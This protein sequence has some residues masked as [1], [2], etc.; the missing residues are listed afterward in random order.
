MKLKSPLSELYT[1]DKCSIFQAQRLAQEIAFG[2]VVFQVSR[3]MVKFGILQALN[4]NPRG[5]TLEEIASS[6]KLSV[7]AAKVLLEASLSIGTVIVKEDRFF[8]TKAGWYLINDR[9][10]QVNM[11]FVQ[12]V[13]YLGMFNLEKCLLEGKP[14]GLKIF[15]NWPTIYQGLS[16][17]PGDVKKSWFDFDHFYSDSSFDE[18]LNI[19]FSHNPKNIMDIGGNTGRFAERVVGFNKDIE[20]TVVDLDKQLE[21]LKEQT[22]QNPQRNRIKTYGCDV[23]DPETVFPKDFDAIWM[24][25]FL[26]CFS[27]EQIE[28]VLLKAKNSLSEDGNIFIMETFWDRQ[29]YETATYCL[30]MTSL[31]FTA[32]ANGNSQMY[33]S[34]DMIKIIEKI[35]LKVEE[36]YDNLAFGHS[37]LKVG[38][39]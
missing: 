34:D 38:L 10:T 1:K 11:N 20:I 26:D 28:S 16:S 17:L 7:Y 32:M 24:S 4:D 23:L 18:A 37:I 3:L 21:M 27:L 29:E 12:D 36:I 33:H 5:L 25:Q 8:I 39:A 22:S 9:M 13:N 2:P 6:T 14:E 19:V 31:Y 15:G 30:T 35:G